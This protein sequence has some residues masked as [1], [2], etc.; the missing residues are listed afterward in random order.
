MKIEEIL[1]IAIFILM[2]FWIW[3]IAD[4]AITQHSS[5]AKKRAWLLFISL[6]FF[7]GALIYY[8]FKKRRSKR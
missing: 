6:T 8:I 7:P 2:A 5:R 4:A 1:T 3:M